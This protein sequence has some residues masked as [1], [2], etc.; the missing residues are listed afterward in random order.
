[1]SLFSTEIK[2]L[3]FF[4]LP[5]LV[6][7]CTGSGQHEAKQSELVISGESQG[8]DA[9][10]SAV[11][12]ENSTNRGANYTDPS[13][14]S[15]S[16]RYITSSITN[17]S[18]VLLDIEIDLS[19]EYDYPGQYRDEKYRLFLVPEELTPEGE[20]LVDTI[21]YEILENDLRKFL[22]KDKDA[23]YS[24]S[25]TL[26]PNEKYIFTIATLYPRP[27][28]SSGVVPRALFVLGNEE[29]FGEC[30]R[31]DKNEPSTGIIAF[32]LKLEFSESCSILSAGRVSLDS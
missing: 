6:L 2:F 13:G 11:L 27:A 12:I 24:I 7:S 23:F 21:T 5:I 4:L 31:P 19:N 3:N 14:T 22:D 9:P 10:K 17:K 28:E 16:F 30:D 20:A 18:N 32:G 29:N 8:W 1:M 25:K 15:L 26:E